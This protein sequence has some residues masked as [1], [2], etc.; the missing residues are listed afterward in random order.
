MPDRT[1]K[2]KPWDP[3]LRSRYADLYGPT[4]GDRIRLADTDLVA[5]SARTIIAGTPP[6]RK[7]ANEVIR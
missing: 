6:T 4:T 2:D 7:N 5:S 1:E 3:L